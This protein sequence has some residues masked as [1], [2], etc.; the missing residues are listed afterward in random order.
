MP[1]QW[2]VL[3]GNGRY[4]YGF[5]YD[6]NGDLADD[7]SATI[8]VEQPDGTTTPYTG[9]DV[10]HVGTG[11]YRRAVTF[12]TAGAWL[13]AWSGSGGL[14]TYDET[15]VVVRPAGIGATLHPGQTCGPWATLADVCSPCDDYAFDVVLL[16]NSLQWASDILYDL[17][18]RRWLGVCSELVR[19]CGIETGGYP[20]A[21]RGHYWLPGRRGWCGCS[22]WHSCGC[23]SYSELR[24][25]RNPVD[26]DSIVVT[27]DGTPVDPARYRLDDGFRLVYQPE[28][29]SADR[30]GWPCCQDISLP[31]GQLGTWTVEY[32]FGE[33]PPVGG[34]M[35]A[36]ILGCQLAL[37]CQPE[38]LGRCRLPKR[39]T[40]ITRQGITV[41]AVLDPMELFAK[42]L[43]GI[44]EV[45]LWVASANRGQANRGA[46]VG[47]PNTRRASFRRTS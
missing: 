42:G 1:N 20:M 9:V 27:I 38:T 18:M 16:T 13:L 43:T 5:F 35:S 2:T 29:P 32:D 34:T 33:D 46:S 39:V 10:E 47:V 19:P 25:P 36:A 40:S 37:A 31:A 23:S 8:T 11:T 21:D 7:A 26:A 17:T 12:T 45:D 3:V 28:S 14:P 4:S 44:P 6:V 15:Y 30:Q 41:A 22:T 24:L